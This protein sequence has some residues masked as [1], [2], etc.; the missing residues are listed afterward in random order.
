VCN[1]LRLSGDEMRFIHDGQWRVVT[2]RPWWHCLW[3]WPIDREW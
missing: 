2:R 3:P 1:I